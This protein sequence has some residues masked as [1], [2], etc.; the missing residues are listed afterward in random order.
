MPSNA[1]EDD[2]LSNMALSHGLEA[3]LGASDIHTEGVWQSHID[4]TPLE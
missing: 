2:W 1:E 3:W 4:K